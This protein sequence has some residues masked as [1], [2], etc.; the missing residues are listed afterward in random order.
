MTP[1]LT[2]LIAAAAAVP[3]RAQPPGW[4]SPVTP[5]RPIPAAELLLEVDAFFIA[6]PRCSEV[7]WAMVELMDRNPN[8]RSLDEACSIALRAKRP[9]K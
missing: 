1:V 4:P 5:S 2:F 7:E 3:A 8:I 6:N 9:T